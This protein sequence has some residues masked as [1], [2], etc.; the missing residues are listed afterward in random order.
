MYHSS[1]SLE[2]HL[3][4]FEDVHDLAL[5]MP[6]LI[7]K[8]DFRQRVIDLLPLD[9][10]VIPE[11]TLPRVKLALSMLAQGFVW[12]KGEEN[13][14]YLPQS[15]AK[16]LVDVAKRL[17]EPP[18]LNYADYVLR[19]TQLIS[20]DIHGID[21]FKTLYSFT[22]MK[23]EVGFIL[24]HV[25]YELE[26]RKAFQVGLKILESLENR[27]AINIKKQLKI[28]YAIVLDLIAQFNT[29]Y[30]TTNEKDFREYF[31]I[32]LKGWKENV[33][34][35]TYE[36]IDIDASNLRGETG[37]QSSLLPFLDSLLGV[38]KHLAEYNSIYNAWRVYMPY[39]DRNFLS[40][41][42]DFGEKLRLF[43]LAHSTL[44]ESYNRLLDSLIHFRKNHLT[45]ITRYIE[46]KNHDLSN[47]IGTGGTFYSN[48]LGGLIKEIEFMKV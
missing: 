42:D 28:L 11:D 41:L 12:C 16:P 18:I 40:C 9:I 36:G 39:E 44:F 3:E 6:L 1:S 27:D 19:N 34:N 17:D 35:M 26:G 33:V 47:G 46:G 21:E 8:G 20:T 2:F 7:K 30:E 5:N 14:N 32:Y 22:G 13:I 37:A 31:R 48:Y 4:F 29:V 43:V 25:W 24:T 23:S 45:T 10:S 15:L 38:S